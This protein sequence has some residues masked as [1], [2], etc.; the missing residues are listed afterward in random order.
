MKNILKIFIL[1]GGILQTDAAFT[2]AFDVTEES[3]IIINIVDKNSYLIPGGVCGPNNWEGTGPHTHTCIVRDGGEVDI[4]SKSNGKYCAYTENVRDRNFLALSLAARS[5][6]CGDI[7]LKM[8]KDGN[9]IIL[10]IG[11]KT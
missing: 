2:Q 4:V 6:N 9:N 3:K 8:G 7:L 10:T 1:I 11:Q 5:K